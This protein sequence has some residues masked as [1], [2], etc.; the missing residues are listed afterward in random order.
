[1]TM[2]TVRYVVYVVCCGAWTVYK[3][4]VLYAYEWCELNVYIV[5]V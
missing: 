1:M 5:Y 3:V 2:C 4:C